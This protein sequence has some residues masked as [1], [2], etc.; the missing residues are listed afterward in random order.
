MFR[1]THIIIISAVWSVLGSQAQAG[2][3]PSAETT[4]D[5]KDTTSAAKRGLDVAKAGAEYLGTELTKNAAETAAKRAAVLTQQGKLEIGTAAQIRAAAR[6][7][8]ETLRTGVAD[9]FKTPGRVVG[10]LADAASAIDIAGK[11]ANG[12][13]MGAYQDATEM[14]V[15]KAAQAGATAIVGASGVA[16]PF[17]ALSYTAG[18]EV[19]KQIRQID[20]CQFRDCGPGRKYTIQDGVTDLYFDAY[21]KIDFTLHPEK[22][23]TSEEFEQ[24]A[25]E[26]AREN[27]R[28]NHEDA[29][30]TLQD[31]QQQKDDADRRMQE[32]IAQ[33][34]A[35][36][37][38]PANEPTSSGFDDVMG[39][40][41]TGTA[42]LQ[43]QQALQSG[44]TPVPPL[45]YA[46]ATSAGGACHP[47]HDESA[48]PGG[49]HQAPLN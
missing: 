9:T 48:H 44:T 31:L 25:M 6:A 22:D 18:N 24:I 41:L 28:R 21:Q 17:C 45:P 40:L 3:V 34:A 15:S 14:A 5:L 19:G 43:Q 42:L 8:V 36:A 32:E 1:F 16:C 20:T 4:R 27:M 37:S 10:G 35:A 33:Q 12:D 11:Y 46:P 26:K 29:A 30:R 49:C 23:P 47:G 2:I 38:T 39:A 13:R 7:D